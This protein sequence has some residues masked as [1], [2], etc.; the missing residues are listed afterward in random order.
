MSTRSTHVPFN[1]LFDGVFFF[2]CSQQVENRVVNRLRDS[3][4]EHSCHETSVIQ[5]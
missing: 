4:I 1:G 3:S 2:K 5:R